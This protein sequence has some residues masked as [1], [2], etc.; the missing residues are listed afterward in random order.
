MG[1]VLEPQFEGEVMKLPDGTMTGEPTPQKENHASVW[2]VV[3]LIS[4]TVLGGGGWLMWSQWEELIA[5]VIAPAPIPTPVAT[6]A[7]STPGIPSFIIPPSDSIEVDSII[8][9]LD[10][11]PIDSIDAE[12]DAFDQTISELTAQP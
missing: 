3:I 6:S 1:Q 7:T 12:I 8:T 9:D 5:P 4:V 11:T 2:V 10:N